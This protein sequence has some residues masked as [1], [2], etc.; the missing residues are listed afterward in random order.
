MR[1]FHRPGRSV[2]M[3]RHGAAA[4]S[5]QQATL[6]AAEVLRNGGSA[7][8][9]AVAAAAL[10]GVIEPNST[11]IGGDSFALCWQA[12]EGK[13]YGINGS[14]HAPEALSTDWLLGQD[15]GRI[16]QD[17]VHSVLVP[18]ALRCWETLLARFG[19]RSLRDL[20]APAIAAADEGFAVAERIAHD[21]ALYGDR[22][23]RH[24]ES[25]EVLLRGGA[26]P[27]AGTVLR[28][29]K[30]AETMRRVAEGGA[31]A[32]YT[33]E[34]AAAMVATLGALGGRHSVDDFAAWQPQFVTPVTTR[35]RGVDVHQIPPNGQGIMVSMMLNLLEGFDH[36]ALDPLGADRFHLQIEAYRLAVAARNEFIADPDHA[37]V[38]VEDLVSARYADALRDRI[39]PARAMSD[40]V[41]E[42][43]APSDTVY[44]TTADAEGNM[45]SFISSISAAFGSAILCPRTGV[46]FQNRGSGFVVEPG[47]RNTVAPRKR[48]LHTIIPGFASRNGAPWLS[49]GVMHGFYQPLGQVQ[50]LQ[51]IVDYGMNVQE[52]IDAPR[53]LRDAAAFHAEPGIPEATM[54]ELIRRGHPVAIAHEPWGGA[55]AILRDEDILQAG[56]DHRKDGAALAW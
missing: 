3:G 6:I 14:G 23:N 26:A 2:A 13:L 39:D 52:A 44:L 48:S 46:L 50:V 22:L 1:N 53:G 38:P 25:R 29:P 55:Q 15:I 47:H 49:F 45:C 54:L 56:S 43:V 5:H 28:F 27:A 31:D 40:P 35:Y 19:R 11:G 9:A 12:D 42:P 24:P 32:F 21:W 7:V 33:G 37:D 20:L 30:L 4:T 34:I 36:A 41:V 10:L 17:S 51:N 18:G 8:D 16:D